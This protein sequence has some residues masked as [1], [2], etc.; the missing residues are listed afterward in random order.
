ME[1]IQL[2]KE[3][4]KKNAVSGE[5]NTVYTR[6]ADLIFEGNIEAGAKVVEQDVADRLGVSRIPVRESLRKMV[7][8]GL[9]VADK[10][11]RGV[12]VRLYTSE[13]RRQLCEARAWLEAGA[14]SSAARVATDGDVRRLRAVCDQM[15]PDVANYGSRRWADLDHDFHS[16]LA[17]ASHN[18]RLA[19]MLKLMLTECHY[20][21][22]LDP[23]RN[24]SPEP[25]PADVEKH[26]ENVK[27]EHKELIDLILAGNADAAER[28][29]REHAMRMNMDG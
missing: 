15:V 28:K 3:S 5:Q 12:R 20:V 10:G 17:D 27:H 24:R 18:Q 19:T 8:Q 29:A 6:V 14:A 26:M 21:F 9:L 13:E 2:T 16:T 23:S 11:G 1:K 22:Y 25:A 7:G 4:S